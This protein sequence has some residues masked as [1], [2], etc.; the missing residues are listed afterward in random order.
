MSAR[1]VNSFRNSVLS[2]FDLNAN[3]TEEVDANLLIKENEDEICQVTSTS[4]K[5]SY[6][7]KHSLDLGPALAIILGLKNESLESYLWLGDLL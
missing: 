4:K 7:I 5:R 6:Y 2:K 1:R 3:I